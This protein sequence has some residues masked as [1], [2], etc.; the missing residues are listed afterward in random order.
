MSSQVDVARSQQ[1]RANVYHVAQQEESRLRG[2]VRVESQKGKTSYFDRLG[3][4]AAQLRTTRHGDTP[5]LDTPHSRRAVTL[6]DYEW[7]DMVDDQDKIRMLIDPTSDYVKAAAAAMGRA[8]DDKIIAAIMGNAMSGEDGSTAVALGNTRRVQAVA[9][10]AA[11]NLNVQALRKA[12][13]L[14]DQA[15]VSPSIPRYCAINASALE[16]LLAETQITSSDYNTVKALVQGEI[17]TFLGFKFLLTEQLVAPTVAFTFDTATGL[18]S[19]GGSSTTLASSK[20]ILCWAGDGVILSVGEDMKAEI[21]VRPDKGFN[22]QVYV[23]M[24]IGAV[25]MEEEKAV[26]ILCKQS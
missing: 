3:T 2:A 18:Y 25:R 1:Y 20:S 13:L 6:S 8:M 26:E 12:K 23:K 16:G 5:I 15:N 22:T 11:S 24:S 10:A 4:V 9:A 17:N 7:G 19:G 21:A 14:L